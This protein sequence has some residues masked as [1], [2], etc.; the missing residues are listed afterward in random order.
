[1]GQQNVFPQKADSFFKLC[2][3]IFSTAKLGKE[4]NFAEISKNFNKK[5]YSSY[6]IDKKALNYVVHIL[7]KNPND[8]IISAAVINRP[9]GEN[10]PFYK[11]TPGQC[12]LVIMA[13]KEK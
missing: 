3:Q 11:M 9:K 10:P 4:I 2:E 1:M 13:A 12:L 7:R 5:K 6:R 8:G